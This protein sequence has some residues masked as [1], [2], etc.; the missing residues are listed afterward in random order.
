MAQPAT[1]RPARPPASPP[2]RPPA[3][4]AGSGSVWWR[5][6]KNKS[7]KRPSN[8]YKSRYYP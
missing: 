8:V 6:D 4:L 3:G 7:T 5:R 2:T 1:S